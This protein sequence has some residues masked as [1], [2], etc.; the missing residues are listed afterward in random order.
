MS[1]TRTYNIKKCLN[2]VLSLTTMLGLSACNLPPRPPEFSKRGCL[3]AVA[4]H[5]CQL[6]AR[7]REA[8]ESQGQWPKFESLPGFDATVAQLDACA[9]AR[10]KAYDESGR[11][12][13]S[14]YSEEW[15]QVYLGHCESE[16]RVVNYVSLQGR[17]GGDIHYFHSQSGEFLAFR[18]WSD[19]L[20]AEC[21][22]EHFGPERMK[23]SG[24]KVDRVIWGKPPM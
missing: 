20:D 13:I 17:Y 5:H 22:G 1:L 4:D 7:S 11:D 9:A 10:R 6:L 19:G 15:P 24:H 23:F 14:K 18:T 3:C 12:T 21:W 8:V 16:G 2:C